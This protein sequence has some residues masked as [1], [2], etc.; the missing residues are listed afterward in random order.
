LNSGAV[1]DRTPSIIEAVMKISKCSSGL[2]HHACV[3]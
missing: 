2:R 3:T 1:Y